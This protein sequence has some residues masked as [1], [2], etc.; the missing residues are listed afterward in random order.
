MRQTHIVSL[1]LAVEGAVTGTALACPCTARISPRSKRS[2]APDARWN[3]DVLYRQ[4]PPEVLE[5]QDEGRDVPPALFRMVD[6]LSCLVQVWC[7]LYPP[8][9]EG[10]SSSL[11]VRGSSR[12]RTALW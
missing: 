10:R 11:S 4:L 1:L 7:A 9:D 2:G 5:V 12:K 8:R 6:L 3:V